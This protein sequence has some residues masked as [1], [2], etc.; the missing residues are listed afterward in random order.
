MK[1]IYLVQR[2]QVIDGSFSVNHKSVL[3]HLDVRG[4]PTNYNVWKLASTRLKDKLRKWE[5]KKNKDIHRDRSKA[6]IFNSKLVKSGERERVVSTH[7]PHQSSFSVTSSLTT[8]LSLGERPVLAPDSVANAP[9]EV[10][11][12]PFSYLIA[13]S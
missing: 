3:V 10:M 13:C 7:F 9:V 5:K 6:S 12:D 2:V 1:E 8:R 4:A 11:N